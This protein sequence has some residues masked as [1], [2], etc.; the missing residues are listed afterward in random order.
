[1]ETTAA[2]IAA[3]E[4]ALARID[5]VLA[6]HPAPPPAF[7]RRVAQR[8]PRRCVGLG[9]TVVVPPPSRW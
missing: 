2:V 5:A 3:A 9:H 7:Q 1:M 4:L 6:D 8:L